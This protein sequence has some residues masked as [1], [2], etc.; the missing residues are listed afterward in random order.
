M[1]T[2]ASLK[3]KS[4]AEQAPLS[5]MLICPGNLQVAGSVGLDHSPR[6]PGLGLPS[7]PGSVGC[8]TARGRGLGAGSRAPDAVWY[9]LFMI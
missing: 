9:V 1:R 5:L 7:V 6:L 8:G 3:G 2:L 4:S